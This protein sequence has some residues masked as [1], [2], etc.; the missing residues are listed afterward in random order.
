MML[1][2][3]KSALVTGGSGGIGRATAIAMAKEGASILITGRDGIATEKIAAEIRDEFGTQAIGMSADMGVKEQVEAMV[4]RAVNEFGGLDI[5]VN[6]AS[7]LSDNV[8]LEHKTDEMLK[9]TLYRCLGM[10]VGH[11]CSLAAYEKAR[12]RFNHQ[13]PQH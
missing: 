8:L 4:Q 9:R 6:N 10:L 1:F 11:A 12:G 2:E 7:L 13:F 5:L 3:N